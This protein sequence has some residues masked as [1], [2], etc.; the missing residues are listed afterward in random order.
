ARPGRNLADLDRDDSRRR[1]RGYYGR[2]W[3]REPGCLWTARGRDDDAKN[4]LGAGRYLHVYLGHAGGLG[5]SALVRFGSRDLA[6]QGSA[7]D[8]RAGGT[9][10]QEIVGSRQ[11]AVGIGRKQWKEV[12]GSEREAAGL[13]SSVAIGSGGVFAHEQS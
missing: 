13:K 11:K 12:I 9:P 3:R 4:H 5:D 1:E 7:Q 2:V 8:A 6:R 10:R